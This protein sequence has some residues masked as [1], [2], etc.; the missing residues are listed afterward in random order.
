M[1]TKRQLHFQNPI[2]YYSSKDYNEFAQFT[3]IE[4]IKFDMF[5]N[6]DDGYANS[7]V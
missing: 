4:I 2:E 6:N 5:A 1:Q 3:A 7:D